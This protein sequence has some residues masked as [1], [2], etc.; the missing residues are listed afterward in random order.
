MRLDK[1][2]S[3]L[4][5]AFADAQSMAVGKDNTGIEPE[6]LLLALIDQQGS[7]VRPMLAQAG[8]NLSRLKADLNTAIDG[9]PTISQPTGEVQISQNLGRLL[10]LS[11]KKAQ[12]LGDAYLSG[13]VVVLAATEDTGALGGLLRNA[14]DP[15]SFQQVT[16]KLRN[17]ETIMDP[18]AD[19]NRQALE[20]LSLI[21][22]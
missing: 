4:Q 2:T 22:I 7:T 1:M 12:Q 13:E 14:G 17:G 10:N 21:H 8:Y 3:Q 9:F 18:E 15:Q 16:E 11:D 19:A 5:S 20:K 6:H